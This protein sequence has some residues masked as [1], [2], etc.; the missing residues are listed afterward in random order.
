MTFCYAL[1][2]TAAAALLVLSLERLNRMT[3][4][5]HWN[6]RVS[7]TLLAGGAFGVIISPLFGAADPSWVQIVSHWSIFILLLTDK[8]RCHWDCQHVAKGGA[9]ESARSS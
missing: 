3:A 7:Y 6:A 1:N 8:R 4:N 2:A 9:Y 5:T